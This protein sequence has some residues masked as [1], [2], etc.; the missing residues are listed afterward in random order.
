MKVL[1][2]IPTMGNGGAEKA[3]LQI[4]NN[5]KRDDVEVSVKCLFNQGD[6]LYD[7]DKDIKYS[8]VFKKTFRGNIFIFKLFSPKFLFKKMIKE[9]YDVIVSFLEG[10]TTRIVSGCDDNTK[11][12]NWV[13]TA[14]ITDKVLTRSYRSKKELVKCYKKYDKTIFVAKTAMSTFFEHFPELDLIN[15]GVCYNPINAEEVL[16]KAEEKCDVKF[17]KDVFNIISVGRLSQVKGFDRLINV[18]KKINENF[19]KKVH[20][21]IVGSGALKESLKKQVTDFGIEKNVTF[22]DFKKN[23]YKY[24][25]QADLYVCSSFR[26]GYSTAVIE[27]LILGVP[28]V[29]TECSGMKEILGQNNDFG[30]ITKNEEKSLLDGIQ[31]LINDSD[32]YIKYKNSAGFRGKEFDLK[33]TMI[34]LDKILNCF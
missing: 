3:L 24:V 30:I 6:L 5:Y 2:L 15:C 27:S 11:L 31:L 20:L 25:K 17:N 1:F 33:K 21:Y 19:D 8:Y 32:T 16:K 4:L 12:I 26:E 14:P 23:P 28:V 22:L 18:I 34:E 9:K 29:T 7:I 10:P 13:H